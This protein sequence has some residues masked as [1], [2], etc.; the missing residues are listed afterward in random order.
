MKADLTEG[1]GTAAIAKE[2]GW[3]MVSA[4]RAIRKVRS[5]ASLLTKEKHSK[6]TETV[7]NYVKENDKRD[8]SRAEIQRCTATNFWRTLARV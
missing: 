1:L 5:G 8:K 4:Q 7:P 6:I 3:H 2:H